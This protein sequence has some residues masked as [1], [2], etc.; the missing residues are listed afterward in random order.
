MSTTKKGNIVRAD[1]DE[2]AIR[3]ENLQAEYQA[4]LEAKKAEATCS[5]KARKAF[6]DRYNRKPKKQPKPKPDYNLS[7][8]GIEPRLKECHAYR[9][10][11]PCQQQKRFFKPK[12]KLRKRDAA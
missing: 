12:T 2:A 9:N 10:A 6:W 3:L 8:Q 5:K 11:P 1:L 7:Q 4:E